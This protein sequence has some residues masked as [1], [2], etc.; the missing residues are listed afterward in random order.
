MRRRFNWDKRYLYWGVTAFCVIAAALLF[1]FAV[2]NIT[3]LVDAVNT[4][5]RILAP[6]IWGV[7]ICYLL[8]PLMRTLENRL[9]LPLARK[10]YKKSKK[11]D[12]RKFAR[13]LSVLFSEII[14]ILI[15]VALVYLILPQVLSSIQIIIQNSGTYVDNLS[16]WADGLFENYPFLDQ[17]IG[18]VFD[19]FNTNF[20]NWLQT[21]LLPRVGN[22]VT[23]IT[24]GVYGVAKS[25]YNLIIGIIVS[26]YLLSDKEGF[27]AAV[28]RLSY[29]VLSVETAERARMG[30]NFVDRTFMSFL[31]GKLLD[32]LIIGIICYVGCAVLRIPYAPLIAVVVGLT[33]MIPVFGPF[34]GAVP[35]IF[36]LL[37][38]SPLKALEFGIFILVLQ[39]LDGNLIGP[40]ILGD[41]VGLPT[42]WVMF[43]IIVGGALFGVIG[44][45]IG[46]PV[47]SVIFELTKERVGNN[48]SARKIDVDTK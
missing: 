46:V 30:I 35:S 36:I 32:S 25:I 13:A 20:G 37:I 19:N 24:S 23:S 18:D 10:L 34:I 45:F 9:F 40:Y 39:Q 8:S 6:F 47:F 1:Y 3:R 4:L 41:A 2:G 27:L 43:A 48:L 33:N 14:L 22:V 17:Y 7:V 44:M 29:A 31:N 26:I 42:L 5:V 11:S 15:L 16:D 38:I 12:G 21:T 28:K